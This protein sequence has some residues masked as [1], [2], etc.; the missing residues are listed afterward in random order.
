VRGGC[1]S[2][3]GR[4]KGPEGLEVAQVGGVR[5][6]R[7]EREAEVRGTEWL[8]WLESWADCCHRC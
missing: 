4:S 3:G 8:V 5:A 6:A 7:G 2:G 1:G